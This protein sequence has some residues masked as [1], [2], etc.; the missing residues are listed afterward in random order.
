MGARDKEVADTLGY[1][2]APSLESALEMA[3][4]TV[5]ASPNVTA[6]HTPPIFLCDVE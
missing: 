1:E 4:D 6:L 2:T 3:E 5:G